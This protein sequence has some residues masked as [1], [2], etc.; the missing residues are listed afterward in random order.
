MTTKTACICPLGPTTIKHGASTNPMLFVSFEIHLR[1]KSMH[2]QS[3]GNRPLSLLNADWK[4][5][6]ILRGYYEHTV[7]CQ[8]ATMLI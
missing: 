2:T 7:V 6:T 5:V 4:R 1:Q 3:Q 8:D